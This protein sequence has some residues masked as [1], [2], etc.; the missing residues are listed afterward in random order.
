[1][2]K[3]LIKSN[4]IHE[5]LSYKA[6]DLLS[7]INLTTPLDLEGKN[8][9]KCSGIWDTGSHGCVI[10]SKLIKSLKPPFIGF[11]LMSGVL[12][13]GWSPEYLLNIHF[14]DGFVIKGVGACE[15][16]NLDKDE[17]LI[18]MDI[19]N[20]GDF[21]ITNTNQKTAFSYR[22]PSAGRINFQAE[23]NKAIKETRETN[24]K[25]IKATRRT[26]KKRKRRR[27]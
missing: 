8:A 7:E 13:K 21:A 3:K 20:M 4:V 27:R 2:N 22:I 24:Q 14:S 5:T 19:I 12:V 16:S 9:V 26:Q 11:K 25:Q 17:F 18:G 23:K 10:S 1:M 15:G 6:N